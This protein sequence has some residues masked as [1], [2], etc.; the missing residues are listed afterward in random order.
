MRIQDTRSSFDVNVLLI[1][2]FSL[3]VHASSDCCAQSATTKS[4]DHNT[5]KNA[6]TTLTD[7]EKL[8]PKFI[9]LLKQK[10]PCP[11]HGDGKNQRSFLFVTD[12]ADAFDLVLHKGE[13][14]TCAVTITNLRLHARS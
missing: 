6:T 8:I 5:H 12:V 4:H 11:L 14:G 10:K 1:L 3:C 7:P 2:V 9:S 13:V